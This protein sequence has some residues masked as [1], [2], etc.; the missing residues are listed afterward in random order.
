MAGTLYV[1]IPGEPIA[2]GRGRAVRVGAGVRVVDPK[3]SRNWKATAQAHMREAM[4]TNPVPDGPVRVEIDAVWPPQGPP[5]KRHPRPEAWRPK[6]PDADNVAKAVLD[7]GNGVLWLDDRQVVDL[8]IMK[9]HA[10]QGA[11]PRVVVRVMK[12]KEVG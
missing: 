9:T 2:Q 3:R 6:S 8:R 11:P 10:A 4:G 5:R 7:A 12:L 1:T